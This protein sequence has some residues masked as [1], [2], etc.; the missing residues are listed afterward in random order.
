MREGWRPGPRPHHLSPAAAKPM[1]LAP[2]GPSQV[3]QSREQCSGSWMGLG[4]SLALPTQHC[5]ACVPKWMDGRSLPGD[6]AVRPGLPGSALP[7]PQA[8]NTKHH[9]L[10]FR[11]LGSDPSSHEPHGPEQGGFHLDLPV[12]DGG[13]HKARAQPHTWATLAHLHPA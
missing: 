12:I 1:A 6:E 2:L 9:N 7:H 3:W 13:R 8:T 5:G 10:E 4:W 11:G